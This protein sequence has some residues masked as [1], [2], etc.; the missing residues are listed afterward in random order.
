MSAKRKTTLTLGGAAE[1]LGVTELFLLDLTLSGAR[2]PIDQGGAVVEIDYDVA[3][4]EVMFTARG[5][6]RF[7]KRCP[8]GELVTSLAAAGQLGVHRSQISLLVYTGV[9]TAAGRVAR[10]PVWS[11]GGG[12][13]VARDEL[14]AFAVHHRAA[15]E[16]KAAR[17]HAKRYQNA[18]RKPAAKAE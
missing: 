4:D 9:A 13:Y 10:L 3:G 14:A 6:E 16:R 17:L 1:A 11:I 5:V 8:L 7:L 12:D 2:Q 18:G 15:V